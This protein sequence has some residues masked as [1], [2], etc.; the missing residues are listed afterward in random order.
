[1]GFY[2]FSFISLLFHVGSYNIVEKQKHSKES[3]SENKINH[4][5]FTILRE[6]GPYFS[7]HKPINK[8]FCNNYRWVTMERS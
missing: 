5:L 1:M 8:G 7:Y 3:Q 6:L 2:S 4:L